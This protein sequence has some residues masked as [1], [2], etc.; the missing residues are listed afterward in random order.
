MQFTIQNSSYIESPPQFTASTTTN[1]QCAI[2]SNLKHKYKMAEEKK[3]W[4]IPALTC[5][6]HK[7]WFC[8]Y[9]IKLTGKD[10]YYICEK[11]Y[12]KYCKVATVG[13]ITNS[14]EELDI[15]DAQNNNKT[16]FSRN[17]RLWPPHTRTDLPSALFKQSSSTWEQCL[18]KRN[19]QLSS[20]MKLQKQTH[21]CG[22]T[23]IQDL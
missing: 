11:T 14:L 18:R 6:N 13:E 8:W 10:V 19:C 22:I 15:S 2:S 1:L 23:L 12:I 3:G 20:R 9:K 21:T 5:D 4:K 7:S 17:P 16:E